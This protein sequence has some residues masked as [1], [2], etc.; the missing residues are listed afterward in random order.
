MGRGHKRATDEQVITAYRETGSVW[1]AAKSLGLA[2][3]TV[4]E[5]LQ[6]L[7]ID[8]AHAKWTSEEDQELGHFYAD[9]YLSLA[10]IAKRLNR[11]SA[12]VAC[13]AGDL[14]LVKAR[15]P[16]RVPRGK[17]YDKQSI[18]RHLKAIDSFDGSLTKYCRSSRL[19]VENFAHAAQRYFP[20]WWANYVRVHSDLQ[21]IK[22]TYCCELFYPSNRRQQYCTRKC[23]SDHRRD[24]NYFGGKRR[25][26]AGV[27]DRVCQICLKDIKGKIHVHHVYGK[28]SDTEN[29]YLVALCS[30]CHMA[31]EQICVNTDLADNTD[32]WIR[33]ISFVWLKRHGSKD[34]DQRLRAFVAWQ[35][36]SG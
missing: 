25:D 1:K 21:Q 19:G 15:P 30:R 6:R 35:I 10:E 29:D 23:S 34:D 3:Q 13:R 26:A 24:L 20:D 2:G 18:K 14:G 17:G 28:Q 7:G 11:T 12:A 36:Q 27:L 32:A 22:C 5:R 16:K 33:M 4:H 8:L 9:P 31:L